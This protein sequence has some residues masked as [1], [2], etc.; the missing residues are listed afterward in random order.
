MDTKH[1]F[2]KVVAGHGATVLRVCRVPI[3]ASEPDTLARLHRQLE[4]EAE[5]VGLL[6]VAYRTVDSPVGPL[7]PGGYVGGPDAKLTLLSLEA[8][9]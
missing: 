2:E 7:L 5:R 4:E 1:P 3:P 9:A 6:D 8:A